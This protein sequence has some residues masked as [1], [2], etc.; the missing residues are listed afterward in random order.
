MPVHLILLH[1]LDNTQVASVNVGIGKARSAA[2]YRRPSKK[3]EDQIKA[4]VREISAR[5][6]PLPGGQV[7]LSPIGLDCRGSAG[8]TQMARRVDRAGSDRPARSV[9]SPK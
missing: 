6:C 1:R 5:H 9:P 2:I 8:R 3:F 7:P 4:R